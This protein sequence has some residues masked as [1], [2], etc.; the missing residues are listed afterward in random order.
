[1]I[2]LSFSMSVQSVLHFY[3]LPIWCFLYFFISFVSYFCCCCY[4]YCYCIVLPTSFYM[5]KGSIRSLG[6]FCHSCTHVTIV[7][8]SLKKNCQ[9]HSCSL[10]TP[11]HFWQNL[12]M[13]PILFITIII[14]SSLICTIFMWYPKTYFQRCNAIF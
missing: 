11:C 12:C 5:V 4:C 13:H 8:I 1:M 2:S 3:D 9:Y 7:L 6:P 14:V 10:C